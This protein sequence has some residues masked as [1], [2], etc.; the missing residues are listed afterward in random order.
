MGKRRK[1]PAKDKGPRKTQGSSPRYGRPSSKPKSDTENKYER[2]TS[3]PIRLNKYIANSGLCSRREADKLIEEGKIKVNGKLVDSMGLK[4]SSQD[5]V[6]YNGKELKQEKLVYVLLNKPKDFITTTDDPQGRRTVM[7]LV[8]TASNERLYPVGRLDRHTTGLLLLTNDGDLAKKLSHPSHKVKKIYHVTLDKPL[9]KN[10]FEALQKGVT[11]EDG[12]AIVDEAAVISSDKTDIGLE[13]HIGR[14]RIVRRIFEHLD[15]N[16]KKL[17]RV[18]YANLTKKDLP[19]GKW[20]FLTP[21]EIVNLK[22]F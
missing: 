10:D 19:R 4:V 18:M 12:V 6:T 7:E 15:Y 20:R 8:K 13:L 22:H 2:T 9:S 21:K 16:V 11:L 14:N 1:F 3:G 17:D 5:I